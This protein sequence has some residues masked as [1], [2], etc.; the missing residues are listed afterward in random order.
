MVCHIRFLEF[1]A[2]VALACVGNLMPSQD[3]MPDAGEIKC[4]EAFHLPGIWRLAVEARKNVG[5]IVGRNM[6]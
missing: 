4:R 1:R 2:A 5:I 3:G 6:L